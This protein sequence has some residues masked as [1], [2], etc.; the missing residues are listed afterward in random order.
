VSVVATV[1]AIVITCS[2]AGSATQVKGS[3]VRLAARLVDATGAP[4]AGRTVTFTV[5][6]RELTA[7]T[8]AT[9]TATTLA[10]VADHGREQ[11]VA[12]RFAGGEGYKPSQ[13]SATLR[14]GA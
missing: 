13:T 3:T 4:V 6:G 7:L 1:R 11:A 8:D 5:A 12:A 9:G 10:L 2:P 14:W